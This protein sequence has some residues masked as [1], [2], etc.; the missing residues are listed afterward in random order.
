M[1]TSF[2]KPSAQPTWYIID[3]KEQVLGRLA[4]RISVVLRGRHRA[5]FVPHWTTGD[6]VVVIN[7]EKVAVSG[8]K[9][10]DKEYH[11]HTGWFGNMRTTTMQEMMDK[12]PT[13]VLR[14]A[15]KGMLPK[16]QTRDKLLKNLHM[17]A[18]EAHPHEAQ[19]PVPFPH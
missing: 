1:K 19:Q 10:A 13:E 11:R 16:N 17:F 7:A 5:S 9:M 12:K 2:P 4:S 15:V 8:D 3:A 6:H 18:G 14:L